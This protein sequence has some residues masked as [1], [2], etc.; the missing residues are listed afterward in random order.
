VQ[1]SIRISATEL[2]GILLI[3]PRV[4]ED[5]RGF[6]LETHHQRKYSEAGLDAQ[7]VQD[8]HSHSKRD[9]LRGL[10]Y[11]LAHPQGKLIYA[12]CGEIFDVA[13]DLRR[14]SSAFGKWY[15][16]RLSSENHLQIY[17]PPG[18]AHGFCVLSDR[19]DVVYKCT[20]FYYADD[21]LGILWSDP[22]IGIRWP[23]SEPIISEKDKA[24]PALSQL[25]ADKLPA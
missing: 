14:S 17:I 7:F 12:A 8:N 24:L 21:D 20:D 25:S 15:G 2:P 13:V 6:F 11:Q 16:A 9:T 19:A 3:E 1:M 23:I 22:D 5:P 10:H 4:F 18:F